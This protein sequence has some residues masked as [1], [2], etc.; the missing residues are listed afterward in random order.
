MCNVAHT[1]SLRFNTEFY[2]SDVSRYQGSTQTFAKKIRNM[3]ICCGFRTVSTREKYPGSILLRHKF[4]IHASALDWSINAMNFML[5]YLYKLKWVSQKTGR[6]SQF[7]STSF[8]CGRSNISFE[9]INT[10]A[11]TDKLVPMKNLFYRRTGV[12]IFPCL[13]RPL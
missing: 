2:Y 8:S 3:G 6:Y 13:I 10:N 4:S 5:S 11:I 1:F 7:L 12:H 9:Y